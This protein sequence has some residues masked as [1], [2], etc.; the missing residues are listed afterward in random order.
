M[1]ALIEGPTKRG[2]CNILHW[3]LMALRLTFVSLLI[4]VI[5]ALVFDRNSLSFFL[6]ICMPLGWG[7]KAIFIQ[8]GNMRVCETRQ[9][10]LHVAIFTE[11]DFEYE[12]C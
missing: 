4:V 1:S 10:P 12:N 7:I 8:Y 5:Y 6:A 3:L 9:L 11:A 2:Y